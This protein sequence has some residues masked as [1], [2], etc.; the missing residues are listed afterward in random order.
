MDDQRRHVE[1]LEILGE[2]GLGEGLDAVVDALEAGLHPLQPE[3]VAQALRDLRARPVGAVERGAE[4]LEELRAV[5]Q[6]GGA[7]L[8][9]DLDR[10]AAGIGGRLQHQRRDRADQHGLGD[11]LRAVAAD[12]AGDFAAAGGVADVDRVL[13]VERLDQRREVVGVGVH[14]VA[15]PRLAGAAMAAA[16]VRDA[17]VAACGQE[18]HLVFPGVGA[19]RPAVAED[20]GLSRCPSPCSRSAC[21]LWW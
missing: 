14:V 1:L 3:G 13:Q 2:V 6:D 12:V 7:D 11:A 21:R 19:Q 10:Q 9:E 15:V 20:H 16:V 8:V 17:A 5:G 18:D 4:V